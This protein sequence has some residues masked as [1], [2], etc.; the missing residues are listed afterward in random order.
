VVRLQRA[1]DLDWT[2][3]ELLERRADEHGD[4][5]PPIF[6]VW[7]W[8]SN[9]ALSRGSA[10]RGSPCS[11]FP[12]ADSARS[13]PTEPDE[14]ARFR[15]QVLIQE[16]TTPAIREFNGTGRTSAGAKPQVSARAG[17][18]RYSREVSIRRFWVRVPG[19]HRKARAVTARA[20]QGSPDH[21]KRVW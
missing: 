11:P 14:P 21:R 5:L 18:Q 6:Q 7:P 1:D 13:A 12:S 15:R 16:T 8:A 9:R 2:L 10:R 20:F 4:R 17:A 3:G 19:V